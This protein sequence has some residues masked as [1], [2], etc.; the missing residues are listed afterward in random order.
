MYKPLLKFVLIVFI[1]FAGIFCW[2]SYEMLRDYEGRMHSKINYLTGDL[3]DIP[4]REKNIDYIGKNYGDLEEITHDEWMNMEC[5]C[6]DTPTGLYG[7]SA[8]GATREERRTLGTKGLKHIMCLNPIYMTGK[9]VSNIDFKYKNSPALLIVMNE[10][11]LKYPKVLN[12][13]IKI[14]EKPCKYIEDL[15]T[16]EE[17]E[18]IEDWDKRHRMLSKISYKRQVREEL[19]CDSRVKRFTI[20]RIVDSEYNTKYDIVVPRIDLPEQEK[21]WWRSWF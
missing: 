15:P 13:I 20:I 8:N 16:S 11:I 12:N 4:Y 6:P 3:L 2:L 18:K 10:Y 19:F 21:S 5:K 9:K 17:A 1:I 7:P 14:V